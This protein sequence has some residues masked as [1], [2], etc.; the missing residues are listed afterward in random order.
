[1]EKKTNS[2][3]GRDELVSVLKILKAMHDKKTKGKSK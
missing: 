1:M 2:K 3:A